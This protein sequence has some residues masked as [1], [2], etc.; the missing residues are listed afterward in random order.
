MKRARGTFWQLQ[1][2]AHVEQNS[3]KAS[4]SLGAAKKNSRN[5]KHKHQQGKEK[6]N[7][8]ISNFTESKFLRKNDVDPPVLVTIGELE[9]VDVSMPREPAELKWALHFAELEKPLIMNST[10]AELIKQITGS[11]ETDDWVGHKIVLYKDDTV[12]FGGKL[13]G[14]IRVRA[15]KK[16]IEKPVSKRASIPRASVPRASE[17]VEAESPY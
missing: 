4:G 16:T 17:P 15:Q 13:V 7:M 3:A 5:S 14:G 2:F 1:D 11:E 9:Q 10:N 12:S 8:H 6:T